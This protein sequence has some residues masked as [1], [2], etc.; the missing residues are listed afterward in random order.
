MMRKTLALVGASAGAMALAMPAYGQTAP[1][2]APAANEAPATEEGADVVVTG[3]RLK[4]D[5]NAT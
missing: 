1:A 3:S 5:P 2:P 4:L